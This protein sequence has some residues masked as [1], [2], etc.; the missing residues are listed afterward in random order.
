MRMRAP[1]LIGRSE[2]IEELD[3]VL[4]DAQRGSGAAVFVSGEPGVGKTR[5]AAEVVGHALDADMVVLRGRC[6]TTGPP[7]PFRPVTE[8]L[9]SLMRNG[10][11]NLAERLGPYRPILGRLVPDLA[12]GGAAEGDGTLVVL[13][14]AVLRLITLA[15]ERRGCLLAIEDL[16]D[17]DVE[18]LAV[19]EYLAGNLRDQ[20]VVVLAT[21]RSEPSAAIEL[22]GAITQRGEGRT[23][24]LRR[25]GAQDVHEIVAGC[26][27]T[28]PGQV[29]PEVSRRVFDDSAGNALIVEELLYSMRAADDLV[30]VQDRWRLVERP[31]PRVSPT[32]IQ[33]AM[34]RAERLGPQGVRLLSVAALLGRSFPLSVVRQVL[35]IDYRDLMEHLQS[36]VAAQLLAPDERGP[37]WYAFQHPLTVEAMRTSLPPIERAELATGAAD[38]VAAENPELT[39]EWCHIVAALRVLAGQHWEAALLYLEVGRRALADGA[40]GTAVAALDDAEGLLNA[41]GGRHGA[42][43]QREILETLLFALADTGQFDRALEVAERI[44]RLGAGSDTQ[45]Q[46]DLHVRLAWAG[47]VAGRWAEGAAQVE[48]A[49]ALLTPD[50]AEKQ[51]VPIDAV[52]AYLTMSGPAS[53]RVRRSEALGWLAVRG[54]ERIDSPSTACQAWYAL[55]FVIRERD[56]AESD[57][58]FRRMLTL[59]VDNN[60]TSWHNYALTGLGGNAW[61]AD[62]DP[63]GLLRA[64]T[65]ALHSGGISLAHNASAVLGLD[66]VLRGEFDRAATEID[67]CLAEASR[68]KLVAVVRYALMAKVVLAAHRVDREAMRAAVAEFA[69]SGGMQSRE[70]P[71][72]SG[73]G[74]AFSA[75]LQEDGDTAR[76]RLGEIAEEW[77]RQ[78]STFYLAGSHGLKVLLD[79]LD[80]R[81]DADTHAAVA[82]STPGMMRWNRQFVLM[83]E[84]VSLGAQGRAPEAEEAFAEAYRLAEPFPTARFL[85][86]RLL[87]EPAVRDGWGRPDEWLREAEE[88]FHRAGVIPIASAC[89]AMLRQRGATVRQRR[90]G[91]ERVP[92]E[93][94]KLGVTSREYEVF[95]LLPSRLGN[96]ALAG[97]LH[98]SFR[99]VE[100][101]VASLVMKIGQTDRAALVERATAMQAGR[102]QY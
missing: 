54:A 79:V 45:R 81:A 86:L 43:Q 29:S 15:G 84:A 42:D 11:G 17:A 24:L 65:E 30:R 44:R 36:A 23:L 61:L 21:V 97:R 56:L 7:V 93:L 76:I 22:A 92:A 40:P 67:E 80:G 88:F 64:R 50:A 91:T 25:F 95:E 41:D 18:T 87:A 75:L 37:D 28:G 2:E 52:D 31:S 34:R 70:A 19:I 68:L 1:L 48:L 62:A 35:G 58:C 85:G 4:V 49:R 77:A 99:T 5:L 47:Q 72:A 74:L 94:R 89:R 13:A 10:H 78:P 26:L 20:P 102:T 96:K 90:A 51:T 14:E 53:D 83:A 12:V 60:L 16:H 66:A 32:L 3:A 82:A 8:A 71:L 6:S 33:I 55:G 38:A 27:G 46:L 100:K 9:L 57:L 98:I 63:A 73:L 59:A 69:A 39:G 101:H